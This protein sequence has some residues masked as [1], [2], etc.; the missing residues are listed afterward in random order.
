M[1]SPAG[2]Q[3]GASYQHDDLR[4]ADRRARTV[5]GSP[6]QVDGVASDGAVG[7][8]MTRVGQRV[9]AFDSECSQVGMVM[10]PRRSVWRRIWV[11]EIPPR[12]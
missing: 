1:R 2:P 5:I 3:R 8:N 7:T 10:P 12:R 4:K 11:D 9:P 6:S